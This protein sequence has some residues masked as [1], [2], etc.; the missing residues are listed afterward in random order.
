MAHSLGMRVIAEG[1]ETKAQLTTLLALGCDMAQ[2]Y[3]FSRPLPENKLQHFL[4]I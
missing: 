4:S 1:V 3:Y 2:G